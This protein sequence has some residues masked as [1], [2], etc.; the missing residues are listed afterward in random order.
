[1]AAEMAGTTGKNLNSP[2]NFDNTIEASR[3]T[4]KPSNII[5]QKMNVTCESKGLCALCTMI[6]H[7][8]LAR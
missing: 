3:I 2:K 4:V 6:D 5:F 7:G 8:R 1:M